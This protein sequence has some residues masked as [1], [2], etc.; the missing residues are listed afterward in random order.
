MYDTVAVPAVI[1]LTIPVPF[2][3]AIVGEL[4]LHVP[5]IV[6][7]LKLV[8]PPAHTWLL[9]LIAAGSGLTTILDTVLHE[10]GNVYVMLALPAD[11]PVATPALLIVA[12]AMLLL[13]HAPPGLV[14]LKFVVMP[15]HTFKLPLIGIG[16]GFT[17]TLAVRTQPVAGSI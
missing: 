16:S 5:L 12:I 15:W 4:L 3:I 1:P 17:F 7:L 11:T 2:T 8:V 10:V 6:A 9:P 14:L 13:V